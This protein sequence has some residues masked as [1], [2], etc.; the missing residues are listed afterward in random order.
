MFRYFLESL[1]ADSTQ[2]SECVAALPSLGQF[3][4]TRRGVLLT[5][6]GG[7]ITYF[8]GVTIGLTSDRCT[9]ELPRGP[10][11]EG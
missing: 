5:L 11:L 9:R 4:G 8:S 10:T 7:L 1:T 6:L 2:L 3:V